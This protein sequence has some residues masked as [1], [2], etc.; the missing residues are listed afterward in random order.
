MTEMTAPIPMF[1][2]VEAARGPV[3]IVVTVTAAPT[4]SVWEMAPATTPTTP[5]VVMMGTYAP[6]QT[7]AVL[8]P[9][10]VRPIAVVTPTPVLTISV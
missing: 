3:M 6:I 9:V 7:H 10:A 1:V 2:A 5:S 8:D 4:M